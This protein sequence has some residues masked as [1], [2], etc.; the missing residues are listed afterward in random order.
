MS[1]RPQC[2]VSLCVADR[3]ASSCGLADSHQHGGGV[4]LILVADPRTLRL[5]NIDRLGS[6]GRRL[7]DRVRSEAVGA[8]GRCVLP[9]PAAHH[10]ETHSPSA[11]ALLSPQRCRCATPPAESPSARP[12]PSAASPTLGSVR[13]DRCSGMSSSRAN[14]LVAAL[15][16]ARR[17]VT[18]TLTL[19][20][21]SFGRRLPFMG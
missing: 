14:L 11:P 15:G 18:V 20:A 2:R 17:I 6:T 1:T 16:V 21:P 12:E 5:C 3:D 8:E 10:R 4:F 13:S 7:S 19:V 9:S